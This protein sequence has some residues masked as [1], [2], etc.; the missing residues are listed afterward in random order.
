MKAANGSKGSKRARDDS[1]DTKEAGKDGSPPAKILKD[2]QFLKS[3]HT[4]VP[5]DGRCPKQGEFL[6]LKTYY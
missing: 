6:S 1:D 3:A 4:V 2:G 5:I